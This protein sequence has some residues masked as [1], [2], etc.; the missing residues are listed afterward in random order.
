[1]IRADDA[2]L[3]GQDIDLDGRLIFQTQLHSLTKGQFHLSVFQGY[4]T[5]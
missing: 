1:M 3:V 2:L 4:E 5:K